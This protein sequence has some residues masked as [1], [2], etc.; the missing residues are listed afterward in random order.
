MAEFAISLPDD[1]GGLMG[2]VDAAGELTFVIGA[3]PASPIR[4]TEMFDLMMRAFGSR[5][6]A[7]L[8]V[9]RRSADASPSVNIDR[10]NERTSSG[11]SLEQS[12]TE[13]WTYTR[14]ARWGFS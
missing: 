12:I 6:R 5:S 4:G 2:S 3:H 7:L 9:W 8:G 1:L 14:A 11:V 10:V 13:T